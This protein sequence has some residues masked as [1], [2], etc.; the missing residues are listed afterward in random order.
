MFSRSLRLAGAALVVAVTAA[1]QVPAGKA[2]VNVDSHGVALQGYDPVAF[3]SDSQP[4]RGHSDLTASYRGAT[5]NFA[6]AEHQR[7]FQAAP[8]RYAPQFGGYCAYGVSQ[9]HTAPVEISTW[10]IRDGRLLLN[11]SAAVR[12]RFDADLAR[13]LAQAD[14]NWPGLVEREGKSGGR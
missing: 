14:H 10:Q 7:M 6:S 1:A 3:F 4:V 11:Y 13:Y 5:Y 8:E 9:G 12:R 2:L